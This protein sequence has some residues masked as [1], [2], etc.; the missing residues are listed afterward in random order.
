MTENEFTKIAAQVFKLARKKQIEVI[1]N[2]NHQHLTRFAN[3]TIHQNVSLK[4]S[5]ITVRIIDGKKTGR[6]STNLFD[7][8]SLARAVETAAT[9]ASVQK[10]DPSILPMLGAQK[11]AEK[12]KSFVSAT[13]KLDEK[14][15]AAAVRKAVG[16][17]AKKKLEAAGIFENTSNFIGVANSNGVLATQDFTASTFSIT[18]QAKNSSGWAE[19]TNR[20]VRNINPEKLA[21]VAIEKALKS[22]NPKTVSPGKYDVVLEHAATAEFMLFLAYAGFSSLAFHENRSYFSGKMGK[23]V[24]GDNVSF[25]DNAYHESLNGMG[26]DFEG[27]PTVSLPLVENGVL[28]GLPYDRKTAK[29]F[30]KIATGHG[31]PQPNSSGGFPLN[32]V[33]EPGDSSL[34]EM[35]KSTKKGI[36][37]TH[38]HYSNIINPRDLSLTGMTR[39]GTFLIENGKVTRPVRNMRYT[40][41]IGR[42]LSNVEM[43]SADRHYGASFFGG[44]FVVPAIKVRDFNFSSGTDF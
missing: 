43:I 25:Y 16:M 38:F 9:I 35:I 32:M 26:F 21:E 14:D 22:K 41:T 44:G 33:M 36:L 39:D 7:T 12:P 31:L 37:V 3:N 11:Y 2:D 13:A 20:D 15:R 42:I 5:D 24:F 34:E 18:A 29:K 30:K 8:A 40:D 23:K 10:P 19:E 27:V 4:N 6:A 1:L 28:T 17:C